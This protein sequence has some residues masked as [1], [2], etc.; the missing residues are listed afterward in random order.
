M[1]WNANM[2]A[3]HDASFLDRHDTNDAPFREK[4]KY[5]I[6]HFGPHSLETGNCLLGGGIL[7]G[8]KTNLKM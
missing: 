3:L 5:D 2:E 7:P 4:G 1:Q 8:S 6:P